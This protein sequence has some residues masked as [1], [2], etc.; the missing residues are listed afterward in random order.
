MK[1]L[2]RVAQSPITA[3]LS[4]YDR[5][6]HNTQELHTPAWKKPRPGKTG[7]LRTEGPSGLTQHPAQR[8]ELPALS[9]RPAFSNASPSEGGICGPLHGLCELR[10]IRIGGR[11]LSILQ[12]WVTWKPPTRTPCLIP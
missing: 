10:T 7:A 2:N 6:H 3:L 5:G 12:W 4:P 1:F 11:G 9:R 8:P